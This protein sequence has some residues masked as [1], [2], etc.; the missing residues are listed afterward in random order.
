MFT[1]WLN[2]QLGVS[3]NCVVLARFV[4]RQMPPLAEPTS[5]ASGLPLLSG[6]TAKEL[7]R[8]D[9]FSGELPAVI[10]VGLLFTSGDG[11]MKF[12]AGPA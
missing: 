7:M 3:A 12:Q 2:C 10:S 8:P 5:M 6:T 4:V 1:N 11:P 9:T